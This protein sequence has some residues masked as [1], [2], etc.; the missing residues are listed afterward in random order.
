MTDNVWSLV[1]EHLRHTIQPEEYR[2]W[3]SAS[4]QASDSGDLITVWVPASADG[5]HINVHYLDIILRR[6][7]QLGRPGV[8]LR[9]VPTGYGDEDALEDA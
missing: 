8:M 2:R 7:E 6:L 9:F 4:A 1:L 5:R 3:F